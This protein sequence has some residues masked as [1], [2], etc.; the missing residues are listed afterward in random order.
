MAYILKYIVSG[1]LGSISSGLSSLPNTARNGALIKAAVTASVLGLTAAAA[2]S[3]ALVNAYREQ[4]EAEQKVRGVIFA[5]GQ[6]AQVT[7]DDSFELAKSLSQ[8][9]T[10]SDEA[11]LGV[12]AVLLSAF[13][14]NRD[15]LAKATETVLN[16]Q[17]RLGTDLK[18]VAVLLGKTFA[19]HGEQ[20]TALSRAGIEVTDAEAEFV[21]S[22]YDTG[23]TDAA[24]D[25]TL[26][27]VGKNAEGLARQA[28]NGTGVFVQLQNTIRDLSQTLGGI[29]APEAVAIAALL[30]KG[31]LENA[32]IEVFQNVKTAITATVIALA[33]TAIETFNYVRELGKNYGKIIK[34]FFTSRE[35]FDQGIYGIIVNGDRFFSEF[36]KRFADNFDLAAQTVIETN[37][38]FELEQESIAR[39]IAKTRSVLEETSAPADAEFREHLKRLREDNA[40]LLAEAGIDGDLKRRSIVAKFTNERLKR[41]LILDQEE[42]AN[43]FDGYQESLEKERLLFEY[44]QQLDS[45]NAEADLQRSITKDDQLLE[46]QANHLERVNDIRQ[47]PYKKRLD[48][49]ARFYNDLSKVREEGFRGIGS[50]VDALSEATLGIT[51][52]GAGVTGDILESVYQLIENAAHGQ[53]K[54]KTL[55]EKIIEIVLIKAKSLYARLNNLKTINDIWSAIFAL[56]A[57]IIIHIEE[58]LAIG[59]VAGVIVAFAEGMAGSGGSFDAPI[60]GTYN[61][62][63]IVVG[64]RESKRLRQ[65]GRL[66][67]PMKLG[68]IESVRLNLPAGLDRFVTVR[69]AA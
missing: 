26:S 60:V 34:G 69:R 62:G 65:G 14:F 54:D 61:P 35:E 58:S 51:E 48:A 2:A 55:G 36:S 43:T 67:A 25:V 68:A 46:L 3:V 66:G 42:L 10:F 57:N 59:R 22:L 47:E 32:T 63:E 45:L 28:A 19:S 30:N 40:R 16:L 56:I 27:I 33:Q 53:A 17:T 31:I 20:L 23:Q 49:Q 41:Q 8:F 64:E 1:D 18:S 12:E 44:Y 7:A 21:R 4:E 52:A 15:Q 37:T 9:T 6:A 13:K 24:V 38:A 11:I 29:I 50:H 39:A 5:Q